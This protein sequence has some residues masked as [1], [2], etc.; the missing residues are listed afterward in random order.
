MTKR[1]FIITG[2]SS[3]IGEAVA[4]SLLE[5]GDSVYGISRGESERLQPYSRYV[6]MRYDL[7]ETERI[8]E[9]MNRIFETI[10]D[11]KLDMTGLINNAAMVEPLRP[12]DQCG[13]EPIAANL[14]ISLIA[15]MVLTSVF[16]K[17]TRDWRVRRKV[18]NIS[19][20]SGTYAA[21]S[22]S[23][24]S[25]AKSGLNMF[26]RCVGAE[27]KLEGNPVE[28]IAIDPGM[29]ETNLQRLARSQS[30]ADFCMAGQ[31]R[32]AYEG[33]HLLS[34][35]T[36]ADHIVRIIEEA[37]EPGSLVRYDD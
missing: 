5:G 31:F 18:I 15:P 2:T 23:V 28:V 12:I 6:H 20:G 10:D 25:A 24:Y 35:E 29:V 17:R 1:C 4:Q 26:T 36:I 22:M 7:R 34:A 30:E 33:G 3:G 32:Q 14:Q 27:Q 11:G 8:E 16:I 37:Y 13:A 21:P 19:S 9:M